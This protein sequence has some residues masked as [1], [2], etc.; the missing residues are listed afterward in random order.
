VSWPFHIWGISAHNRGFPIDGL[1]FHHSWDRH[2]IHPGLLQNHLQGPGRHL[3]L[4]LGHPCL[5]LF[6][7]LGLS[8]LFRLLL[9]FYLPP[10]KIIN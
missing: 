6:L 2:N 3:G 1:L 5:Y 8:A 10:F 9:A 4:G 7:V